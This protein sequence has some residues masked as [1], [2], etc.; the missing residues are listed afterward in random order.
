[1][2]KIKISILT[3]VLCIIGTSYIFADCL[4]GYDGCVAS[5]PYEDWGVPG[6]EQNFFIHQMACEAFLVGCQQ[7]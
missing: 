7:E 4:S 5:N 3:L 6:N 1:M 2:K